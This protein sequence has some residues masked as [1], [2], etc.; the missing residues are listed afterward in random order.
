MSNVLVSAIPT[1]HVPAVWSA[2]EGYVDDALHHARGCYA[3]ED[4]YQQLLSGTH[5]LWIAFEG[6]DIKGAVI[7]QVV[8][9]P[10]K[11]ALNCYMAGGNDFASWKTPMMELLSKF[12]IDNSCECFEATGRPGWIRMF[13]NEGCEVV[14]QTCQL[15]I[16]RS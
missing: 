9:Y 2:V 8:Q 14:W 12:A 7:T 11:R 5:H 1:E 4:I 6:T 16:L 3:A 13:K 15:P 10:R